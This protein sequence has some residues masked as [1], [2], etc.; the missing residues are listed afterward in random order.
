M[1][2]ALIDGAAAPLFDAIDAYAEQTRSRWCST[3]RAWRGSTTAPPA[4]CSSACARWPP[5]GKTIELRDM[6]HLVAALF[7]LMGY[8]DV[9]RLFPHKY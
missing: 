4:R 5:S 7:K 3:A 1:L 2:P 6:N 8:A 9:A